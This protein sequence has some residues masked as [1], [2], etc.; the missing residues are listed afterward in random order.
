MAL[1]PTTIWIRDKMMNPV[2]GIRT[3]QE[4]RREVVDPNGNVLGTMD[5]GR[6]WSREG[7]FL[8]P[9]ESESYII[10]DK[11]ITFRR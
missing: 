11:G 8:G 1:A 4:G 9:S 10:A 2:Y 3:I 7:R 5:H 6:T